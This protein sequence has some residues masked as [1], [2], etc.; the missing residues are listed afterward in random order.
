MD[1]GLCPNKN[2]L[3]DY[4]TRDIEGYWPMAHMSESYRSKINEHLEDCYTCRVAA[5]QY[6]EQF[7][8]TPI[9]NGI[10]LQYELITCVPERYM[11]PN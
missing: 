9:T 1:N 2:E 4:A 6:R 5:R 11:L 8:V 3:I 7:L 10:R